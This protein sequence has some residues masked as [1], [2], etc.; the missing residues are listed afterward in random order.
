MKNHPKL[1]PYL[2][3]ITK[4]GSTN[5]TGYLDKA[6]CQLAVEFYLLFILKLAKAGELELR[7]NLARDALSSLSLEKRELWQ[8]TEA[9]HTLSYTVCYLAEL[10]FLT[11]FSS[12]I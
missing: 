4:I 3:W 8:K 12:R 7:L 11:R 1:K 2:V 5:V 9:L 10:S 6:N